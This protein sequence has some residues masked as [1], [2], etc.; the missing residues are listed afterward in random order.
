MTRSQV[1][2]SGLLDSLPLTDLSLFHMTPIQRLRASLLQQRARR[3]W[4]GLPL[5][6]AKI[7]TRPRK[8]LQNC[9]RPADQHS[10]P[11]PPP[12]REHKPDSPRL[13]SFEK[14]RLS[15]ASG[16]RPTGCV[17]PDTVAFRAST[18]NGPQTQRPC[19]PGPRVCLAIPL[20]RFQNDS[21]QSR[22]RL[23]PVWCATRGP[24]TRSEADSTFRGFNRPQGR[25][26]V[27]HLIDS[28][29]ANA[30]IASRFMPAKCL[31]HPSRPAALLPTDRSLPHPTTA[32][33]R[34]LAKQHP[35]RRPNVK[36]QRERGH[37]ARI[38][39]RAAPASGPVSI[40]LSPAVPAAAL[41]RSA[42]GPTPSV[43][44]LADP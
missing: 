44:S 13:G 27:E 12:R 43:P 35:T 9:M 28:S 26:F 11:R 22:M 16:F 41:R 4:P 2:Q 3:S 36:T 25:R 38:L 24:D 20:W 23:R 29:L 5:N 34:A 15:S 32:P 21:D 39:R 42:A 18:T 31:N 7:H 8:C 37:G 19:M 40:L 30:P 33:S 10:A 14:A 17:L 6:P 1:H